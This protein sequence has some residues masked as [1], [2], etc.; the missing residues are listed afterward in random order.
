MHG[1][2]NEIVIKHTVFLHDSQE[3][4]DDLGARSDEDL[5]LSSLLGVVD[6]IESVVEN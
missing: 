5:S 6:R 1:R 3:L 2:P 4:D